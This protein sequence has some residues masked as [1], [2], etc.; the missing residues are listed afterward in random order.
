MLRK[1]RKKAALLA[2]AAKI[3]EPVVSTEATSTVPAGAPE[4][5]FWHTLQ[6]HPAFQGLS[7]KD[8]IERLGTLGAR[9]PPNEIALADDLMM[10]IKPIA[11]YIGQS[12]RVTFYLAETGRL[13]LFKLGSKWAGRKST[14]NQHLLAL[15]KSVGAA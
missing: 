2:S 10:G 4:M 8:I 7:P 5:T 1:P 6:E 15:E 3:S 13:P 11:K 14:I 9:A 12:E